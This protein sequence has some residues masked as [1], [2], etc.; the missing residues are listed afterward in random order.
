MIVPAFP[1]S[2]WRKALPGKPVAE[3]PGGSSY[4]QKGCPTAK[5]ISA[6]S[7]WVGGMEITL[8]TCPCAGIMVPPVII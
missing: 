5:R 6:Q 1:G 4:S 7:G 8:A 2:Q 3:V